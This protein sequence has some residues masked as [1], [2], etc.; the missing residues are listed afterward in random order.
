MTLS[1]TGD[2]GAQFDGP[3]RYRLWRTWDEDS[4]HLL[5]VLL[6][7]SVAGA[8]WDDK[9]PTVTKFVG[10]AQRLGY[11]SL[12]IVNLYALR[13]TYP[14]VL[15][16]TIQERGEPYAIGPQNDAEI[17]AACAR[18]STVIA[19]WGSQPFIEKRAETVKQLLRENHASVVCLGRTAD[20]HPRHPGRLAYAT[21]LEVFT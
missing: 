1:L 16:S 4:P 9:D 7:P 21:E 10:F 8:G 11:G 18:A 3:Y 5:G 19:A 17:L 12:E 6:N 20:G 14:K 15:A 2:A 13:T